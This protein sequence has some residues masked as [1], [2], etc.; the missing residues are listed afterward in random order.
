MMPT[1]PPS[2]ATSMAAAASRSVCSTST[3][4]TT[5]MPRDREI[6][7]FGEPVGDRPYMGVDAENLLNDDDPAAGLSRRVRAPR[8]DRIRALRLQFNPMSHVDLQVLVKD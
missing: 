1:L 8:P 5:A 3:L 7:F 4:P 6:A 2:L